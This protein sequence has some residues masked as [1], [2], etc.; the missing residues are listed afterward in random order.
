MT[1]G[2]SRHVLVLNHFALPR[3]EG[4]GTRHVELFSRLSRWTHLIVAGNRNNGTL[5]KFVSNSPDFVTVPVPAYS[6]NG[7][8]RVLNWGMY[9]AGALAVGLT[10]RWRRVADTRPRKVDVVYASSPHLLTPLAGW[11]LAKVHRAPLV[12][13]IRDLWPRSMVELGYLAEGSRMHRILVRLEGFFYRSAKRIVAVADGW[14]PHFSSFGVPPEKVVL[15]S[16]GAEPADFTPTL[17]RDKARAHL[18]VDGFVAVYAGTHGPANG[19]D[20]IL[21]IA[22]DLT[23]CTFLLVGSGLDKERLVER[24]R[25]ERIDNVRFLEPVPKAELG[26]LLVACDVGLHTLAQAE[27]F[28]QALSPNKLYDYMAAGLPVITNV[29]GDLE[30]R[31]A[32]AGCGVQGSPREGMSARQSLADAVRTIRDRSVDERQTMGRRARDYVERHAS[33]TAMA[34]RLEKVLDDV[35][36]GDAPVP[37]NHR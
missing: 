13:E 3:S 27:L 30:M 1:Q 28:K 35:V 6:S 16:N 33:R 32:E 29:G 34:A 17:T 18:G 4:G 21:D 15:V 22:Q 10:A 14:Q 26:D 37:S 11:L 23:D 9:V 7:I 12:L 36:A 19:L 25:Q 20:L 31:L 5:Q 24:A 2:R 8:G